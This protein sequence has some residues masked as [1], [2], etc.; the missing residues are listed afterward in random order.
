MEINGSCT[1]DLRLKPIWSPEM[2][3]AVVVD[4][5]QITIKIVD[6]LYPDSQ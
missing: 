4:C 3:K 6:F 1:T 2:S 5:V